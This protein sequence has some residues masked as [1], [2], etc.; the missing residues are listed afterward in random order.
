MR[1]WH[2]K[3][4]P[5]LPDS[6]LI[7]QW[8]ELNAIL[9][10]K[11]KHILINYVYEHDKMYLRNYCLYVIAEMHKRNFKISQESI[12]NYIDLDFNVGKNN[13]DFTT[14]FPE[15]NNRYLMQCFRN[16]QE[17]Y[18]R[19]QKDF[20]EKQYDDLSWFVATEIGKEIL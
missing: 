10:N 20:S 11:P 5:Y 6:Q 2:Y 17:K 15:H 9:R 19:G 3:L 1:L 7:A 12:N 18:D 14:C 8:R 16:L 13:V 4:I